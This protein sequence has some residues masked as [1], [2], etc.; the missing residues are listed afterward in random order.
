MVVSNLKQFRLNLHVQL[1]EL[2]V[3][4]FRFFQ[5]IDLFAEFPLDSVEPT[6]AVWYFGLEV[7]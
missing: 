6:E 2:L 7:G 1:Q 4:L 3:E 5:F